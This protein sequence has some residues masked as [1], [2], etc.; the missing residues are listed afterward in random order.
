LKKTEK[1]KQLIE[2]SKQRNSCIQE[3]GILLNESQQFQHTTTDR[4][5]LVP[6]KLWGVRSQPKAQTPQQRETYQGR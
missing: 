1:Q 4:L 2:I 3:H 5:L 6:E